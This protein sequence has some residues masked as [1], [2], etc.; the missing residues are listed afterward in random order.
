MKMTRLVKRA[1]RAIG[2]EVSR[3]DPMDRQR[4]LCASMRE[5][6]IDLVIDV[7]ANTGQFA[8][9][10]R[11]SGYRGRIVSFEPLSTA[12]AELERRCRGDRSWKAYSRCALGDQEGE[13]EL[14]VSANAVSSSL[15]PMMEAHKRAAPDSA[16]L[17]KEVVAITKLDT[18][19]DA[20]FD[21][22]VAPLLKID[23][24]GFEWQVLDGALESLPRVKAVLV[25]LS[26]TPLYEGQHLWDALVDRLRQA[27]FTLWCLE[28][29]FVDPATGRTLQLDGLFY[30]I[31]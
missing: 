11:Q 24:Q 18:V 25:E 21:E 20:V 27:G 17:G 23:T 31:A 7:G 2:L 14:N 9:E 8:S 10:I 30:R 16:Y 1:F 4:M 6:G 19:A 29:V 12:H 13:I 22:A 28:P 15:L 26:L 5:F 3:Y